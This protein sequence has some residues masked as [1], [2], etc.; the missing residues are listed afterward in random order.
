MEAA[1]VG[2][3]LGVLLPKLISVLEKQIDLFRDFKKDLKKLRSSITMIQSFLNDAENKQITNGTVKLWL[4]K[5]EGV[6]F[7]ADNVLDE[8]DYQHLSETIHHTQHKIKKKVRFFFPRNTRRLKM[9]R[10]IKDINKN[11]EEINKEARSYGLQ[12][13]VGGACA[14]IVGS[15]PSACRETDSFSND[16]IFLGRENDVSEIVKMMTT[17]PN[18]DQVFSILPIVGMGGLGKTTVDREVFDHE[19]KKR[20]F[21]KRFWNDSKEKWGDFIN[22]LRK[23]SSAKGNGIVVTIRNQ[24]VASL[25]TTL[26]IHKLKEL[27]EEQ[28]W[29]IIEAKP[30]PTDNVPSEFEPIA[31]KC[32]G[33]PLAARMVGGLL[34]GKS[35]DEWLHIEENWLS[36]LRDENSVSKILKLSFDYLSSPALKKCFAYCSIYPKGYDLPRERLVELWMA[37]G[38]LGGNDDMEIVGNKFFHNLLENFLLLQVVERYGDDN[39]IYYNMH[40]LVHDLASSILN[41]SDQVRYIG[42]ESIDG[43]SHTILKKQAS[44]LRS[45]RFNNSVC[46][47]VFSKFKS[48]HVLILTSGGHF[49]FDELPS[50]I[51]ELIHFRCLDIFHTFIK[52][53]PDSVGDLYH[54]QTLRACADL[55]KLPNTMKHLMNLRHLHLPSRIELPMK[56]GRLISLRT[57]IYFGVSD[58]KGCGIGELG[59]LKNLKGELEIYNLEKVHDKEE[60]K[61]ANLLEKSNI[62]KL[63][64]VWRHGQNG[65]ES[66]LEGLQLHPNLKSLNICGFPGSNLPPWCSMMS[67]LNNLMEIDLRNCKECEQI[68]MLGHLRHLKNLYLHGMENVKSIGS[69]FYGIDKCSRSGN[70]LLYFRHL[71]GSSWKLT[72]LLEAELMPNATDNRR[73]S[74]LV[75]VFPRLEYL[76]IIMCMQLESAPSHFP[77]LKELEIS[78]VNRLSCLREL[79]IRT[80]PGL[81]DLPSEMMESCAESLEKL[82]LLELSNLRMNVGMVTGC[83][84]KMH[85]L[86]ELRI[87]DIPT[88]NSSK[89]GLSSND[90]SLR[91]TLSTSTS[92]GESSHSSVFDAILKGSAKSL[93]TLYLYGTKQSRDLPEQLQHLT[94]PL[95]IYLHD[96]EEIEELPDWVIGNNNNNL[97]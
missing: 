44:C 68:P 55:E 9:A 95:E 71:K 78:Q 64:L 47:L 33:L 11:L 19:D 16:P 70:T 58:K 73:L 79:S 77:C 29:S 51:G 2:A 12:M 72:E 91:G 43:Q 61:R 93:C 5:L 62:V 56:M 40:D 97:S 7:D 94:A 26:P 54:L 80:C 21:V 87:A 24:S 4:H 84:Q 36:D 10:K 34:L 75:V 32:Q 17:S 90:C 63:K 82:E 28:C 49:S 60:A 31:K 48:L 83:L 37:D 41:S 14:P 92:Y 8:L 25:V 35:I 85:R 46:D 50:S 45:L 81:T 57:L 59:S 65:N 53:L 20:H 22:P 96:F 15:Y 76:K 42:W 38:F 18:G 52:C 27:S 39:I 86:S 69:S 66:V 88:T 1:P 74:Q 6:A 13:A 67:E 89:I 3:A 23:I 30:F